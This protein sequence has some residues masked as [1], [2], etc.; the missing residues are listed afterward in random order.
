MKR[1]TCV[2]TGMGALPGIME[3]KFTE[4]VGETRFHHILDSGLIGDVIAAGGVTPEIEERLNG[5]FSAAAGTQ[6][7]VVVSTC[8]S[9]G[10]VAERYAAAN[11]D[12]RMLRVDYPMA[13]YAAENA[14][15]VAVLATLATTVD[16]SVRLVQ[17]LAAEMGREVTVVS[18][19][20]E[21]AFE[22][23]ISGNMDKATECVIRTAREKC[24]DADVVLLA[25]A[26]MS[27]FME[28]LRETLGEKT[29]L[30]SPSTCAGYLKE[31]LEEH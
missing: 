18:A 13:R 7:D 3:Q 16:P 14:G 15:R 4:A 26:S 31:Y 28:A 22:A 30:D 25:Q 1:I 19:V 2:H 23:M 24:M 12:V 27:N 21:G 10:E 11:P 17:R 29:I 20:A 6:P 8:S 9:I 5:L